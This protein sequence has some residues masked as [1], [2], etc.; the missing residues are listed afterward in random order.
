VAAIPLFL[1]M[2]VGYYLQGLLITWGHERKLVT[3]KLAIGVGMII[4]FL[5]VSIYAQSAGPQLNHFADDKISFD[6]PAAYSVT[7]EST[8]EAQQL[9][10]K[11]QGSSVQLTIVVTARLV[12]RNELPAA[13]ENFTEQLLKKV[14]VT[15]GPAKNSPERISFKTQ[16]GTKQAEGVR[17]RSSKRTAEVI[18]LR[19][20]LRLIGLA[21][22]RSDADGSLG[23]ELWQAVSSS[24]RVEAP[25]IASMKAEAKPTENEKIETGVLNGKALAL[26]QPAY[27]ALARKAHASGTVTVQVIIDEQGNVI[28]AHAVDGHPL[29]Q[30]V[31][32]TAARQAQFSPT[33]LDGE[34]V[35]V[36]GVIKYNFISQ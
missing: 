13:S 6:Y 14:A 29:L 11:R 5:S 20:S 1:V 24:L 35:K 28:A 18:W 2:L 30:S 32:V 17:L 19:W 34:P 33:L 25:V 27:P 7:D 4:S 3:T 21:F 26:P 15:L 8:P 31:S 22:V 23:S 16:I 10:I 12:L 9:A 36:T